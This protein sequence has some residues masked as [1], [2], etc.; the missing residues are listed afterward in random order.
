MRMH[1]V[2]GTLMLPVNWCLCGGLCGSQKPPLRQ[3]KEGEKSILMVSR[4]ALT[5]VLVTNV[6]LQ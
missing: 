5:L 3:L 1:T 4:V 2:D 6:F